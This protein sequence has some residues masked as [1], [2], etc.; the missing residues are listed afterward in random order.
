[1]KEYT[2]G[3]RIGLNTGETV[4]V[5]T[6]STVGPV[7]RRDRLYSFRYQPELRL[8]GREIELNLQLQHQ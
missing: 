1:M 3:D 6:H 2:K 7:Y 8:T 4:E 5:E